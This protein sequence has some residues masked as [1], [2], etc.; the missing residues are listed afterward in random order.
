MRMIKALLISTL[1]L[2]PTAPAYAQ[3]DDEP[4]SESLERILRELMDE[5]GPALDELSETLEIF[6]RIDN[7][8]HY[9]R[10][11]VLPNGDIIIRRREDAPPYIPPEGEDPGVRT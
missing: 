2:S 1:L 5:V 8:K 6:D 3:S 4:L 7:L 11:D 9:E 10:P